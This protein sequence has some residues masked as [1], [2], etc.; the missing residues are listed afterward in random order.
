[1]T[2]VSKLFFY[3]RATAAVKM[4]STSQA[5]EDI[6]SFVAFGGSSFG[7]TF[8]IRW[9]CMGG[10]SVDFGGLYHLFLS[11]QFTLVSGVI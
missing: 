1:M 2:I 3:I 7:K 5:T 8:F 4:Y 10:L 11:L 9:R 6:L